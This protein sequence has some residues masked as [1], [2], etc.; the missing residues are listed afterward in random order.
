MKEMNAGNILLVSER[1]LL[2]Y[3][4]AGNRPPYHSPWW[5]SVFSSPVNDGLNP[6]LLW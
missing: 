3:P 2:L 4:E 6:P 5:E 1:Q